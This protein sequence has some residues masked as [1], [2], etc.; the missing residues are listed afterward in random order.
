MPCLIKIN[1]AVT[2]WYTETE[3]IYNTINTGDLLWDCKH[4]VFLSKT[5][6]RLKAVG[7]A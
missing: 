5:S 7:P 3:S 1:A 6:R 2:Y 4:E